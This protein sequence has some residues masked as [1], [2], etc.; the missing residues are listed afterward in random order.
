MKNSKS[1]CMFI[2]G[3]CPLLTKVI[4]QLFKS[5]FS[6]IIMVDNSEF[7]KKYL[8]QYYPRIIIIDI[9][10]RGIINT[11]DSLTDIITEIKD[12]EP[13]V[14]IIVLG[15]FFERDLVPNNYENSNLQFI[16]KPWNNENLINLVNENLISL[17][18]I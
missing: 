9:N 17:E 6:E 10:N 8:L 16:E 13:H 14:K 5:Y 1:G 18:R 11:K 15:T 12:Y 3:A 2:I 7:L 4:N